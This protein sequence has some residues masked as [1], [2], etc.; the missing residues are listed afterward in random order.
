MKCKRCKDYHV[1]DLYKGKFRYYQVS[2]VNVFDLLK[3]DTAIVTKEGMS[4]LVA[5]CQ[6]EVS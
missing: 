3:F 4:Q 2:G 5:R 6:G 1:Y